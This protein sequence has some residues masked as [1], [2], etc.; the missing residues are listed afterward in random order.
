MGVGHKRILKSEEGRSMIHTHLRT[1]KS[2]PPN[3]VC[4]RLEE[5][6]EIGNKKQRNISSGERIT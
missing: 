5:G 6:G 4:K 2:N 1:V 3:T